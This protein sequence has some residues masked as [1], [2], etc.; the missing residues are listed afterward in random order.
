MLHCDTHLGV[1]PADF[2]VLVHNEMPAAL[3]EMGYLSNLADALWL[4][5]KA[6]QNLLADGILKGIISYFLCQ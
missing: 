2:Q 1:S 4:M 5:D 3:I 6:Y